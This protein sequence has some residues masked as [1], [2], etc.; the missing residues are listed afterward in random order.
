MPVHLNKAALAFLVT[1]ALLA[2]RPAAASEAPVV[3]D[4]VV[5]VVNGEIITMSDLQRE[6]AKRTDIKDERIMLDDM[7]DRKLE[8]AEAKKTGMDVTDKELGD[9]INDIMKRNK[10][11]QKQFETAIEKE[12]LTLEQY[13]TEF[14]EQMTIARVF[15]KY[16]RTGLAIDEAEARAYYEKNREQYLLP[17]E[18]H[19]RHLVIEVPD[20]ASPA[21]VESARRRT[22]ELLNR[23]RA[24]E[25]FVRLIR[26]NSSGPTAAQDGDLGF[27]QRSQALPEIAEAAQGLKVGEYAGPIKTAD[28]FQIIKIEEIRRQAVPFEKVKEDITKM[29]FEQKMENAY[30]SWL[31]TLRT[32]SHIENHL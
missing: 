9:A 28:G 14:R 23:L 20:T 29:L 25:N 26:E 4:R 22:A 21:E 5:A 27:L 2:A 11:D 13:R 18:T 8:M 17:E 10:M 7:I 1:A 24:G 16:V 19:I 32:Q 12:G 3:V 31:Q 15:N 6:M 30:R